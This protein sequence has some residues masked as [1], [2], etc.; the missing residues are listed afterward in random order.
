MQTSIDR[1]P[2]AI[3]VAELCHR[4]GIGKTLVYQEIKF[5]RL[6]VAKIGRRTLV[7]VADA[8][9]WFEAAASLKS[10]EVA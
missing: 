1:T 8:Q 6:K 3:S 10:G 7:R 5:G 4:Y 2:A 9:A